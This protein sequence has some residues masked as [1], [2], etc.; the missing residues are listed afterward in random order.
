[1]YLSIYLSIDIHAHW[2]FYPQP[3]TRAGLDEHINE[4]AVDPLLLIQDPPLV[5]PRGRPQG[6]LRRG[7]LSQSQQN[8]QR[9]HENLTQRE[10]SQFELVQNPLQRGRG[11]G[12]GH[13]RGGVRGDR[14]RGRN[15]ELHIEQE[16]HMEH[17]A[18]MAHM[19]HIEHME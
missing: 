11:R 18:H 13:G 10:P 14:G 17:E 6:A 7:N 12:R 16:S 8:R 4:P 3:R 2:L 15:N 9:T 1:M 5:Q 19:E